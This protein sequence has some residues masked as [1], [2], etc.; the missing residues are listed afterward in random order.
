MYAPF[1]T[2]LT[3]KNIEQWHHNMIPGYETSNQ[4]EPKIE[5][6]NE[7]LQELNINFS[8]NDDDYAKT[9]VEDSANE[10]TNSSL[11][12]PEACSSGGI[13]NDSPNESST[14]SSNNNNNIPQDRVTLLIDLKEKQK[15]SSKKDHKKSSKNYVNTDK[16]KKRM[17]KMSEHASS[18][19][20][21]YEFQVDV[22][23]QIQENLDEL[24]EEYLRETT[25]HDDLKMHYANERAENE[26]LRAEL[27]KMKAMLI[28]KEK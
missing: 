12:T 4:Q 21:E 17:K 24:G 18:L 19:K 2:K 14:E 8:C 15:K 13:E 25:A 1:K 7:L 28:K 23:R 3:I 11:L 9:S 10:T 5:N 22:N 20:E 26:E 6:Y 27:S 16:L